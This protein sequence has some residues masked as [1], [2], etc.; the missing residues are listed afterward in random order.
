[1]L[2][3]SGGV[4]VHDCK[5]KALRRAFLCSDL[6]ISYEAL[7]HTP[8]RGQG[9]WATLICQSEFCQEDQVVL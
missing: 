3:N 4:C 5:H 9:L 6:K 7:S 8:Q 1:M 2:A